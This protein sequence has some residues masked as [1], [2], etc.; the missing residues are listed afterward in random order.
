MNEVLLWVLLALAGA[1]ALLLA[2]LIS[3]R[4]ELAALERIERME[5]DLRLEIGEAARTGRQELSGTL[6][7]FQQTMVQQGAE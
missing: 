2:V 5:R 3:R 7:M 1:N 4:S 6:A